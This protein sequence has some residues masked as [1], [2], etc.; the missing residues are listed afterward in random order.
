[1]ALTNATALGRVHKVLPSLVCQQARSLRDGS[2]GSGSSAAGALLSLE[3]CHGRTLE[4]EGNFE[5]RKI[6]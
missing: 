3:M 6:V 4:N 2:G 5:N 1:M